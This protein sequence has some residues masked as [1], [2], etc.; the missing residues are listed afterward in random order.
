M[1]KLHTDASH[2]GVGSPY[3]YLQVE[4]PPFSDRVDSRGFFE[5]PPAL[6]IAKLEG[7]SSCGVHGDECRVDQVE[8]DVD[9]SK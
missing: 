6:E 3:L 9:R 4:I 7:F 8:E 1:V 2:G 5:R